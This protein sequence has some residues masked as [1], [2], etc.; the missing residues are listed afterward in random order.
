MK[1][2]R[3][4]VAATL[5]VI[6]VIAAPPLAPP[7][8]AQGGD[9]MGRLEQEL[10][11]TDEII[12]RA[13]ELVRDAGNAQ[14]AQ[15][16]KKAIEIQTEAHISFRNG[17]FAMCASQTKGARE[18]AQKAMGLVQRPEERQD[19]VQLELER[20]DEMIQ[21]AREEISPEWPET[22]M[23]LL[24]GAQRQQE[25][26]WEYLRA[27]Q[28]RPALRLTLQVREM[29]RKLQH[30]M[31]GTRPDEI[32]R[33]VEQIVELVRRASGEAEESGQRHRIQLAERAREMLM[34]AQEALQDGRARAAR[35][36]LQQAERLAQQSL[37]LE[38]R[39]RGAEE[40]EAAMMRYEQRR[41]QLQL[42]LVDFP[43]REATR[44]LEE[45]TEHHRLAREQAT[46]QD[47]SPERAMAE[48][49]IAM[50]L[51]ERAGELVQ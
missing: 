34:R 4:I 49:R 17:R 29:L 1:H 19:R 48:L 14:A 43:S 45:S 11:R 10:Q 36:H 46:A 37:R 41:E 20:T 31:S 5:F 42:R 7:A 26:A 44:L 28:L 8:H 13:V 2:R 30:H 50:R 18:L 15:L 33:E 51:L 6:A 27:N 21:A 35:Q 25:N 23:A 24:A 47:G 39:Q 40:F 22:A 32:R 12:Q 9:M 38:N 16:V 3:T